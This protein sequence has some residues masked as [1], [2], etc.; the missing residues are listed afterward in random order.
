[1]KRARTDSAKDQ[2][3]TELLEAALNEFYEKGFFAARMDDIAARAKLSK[4]TLYL[5]FENK[6]DVFRS[7]IETFAVANAS[8]LEAALTSTPSLFEGFEAMTKLVPLILHHSPMPKLI[9]VLVGDSTSFPET[10][11]SYRRNVI[12]RLHGALERAV[13]DAHA[14]GEI[15]APDAATTARLIVAPLA[16]SMLWQ[17]VFA[18]GAPPEKQLDLDKLLRTHL[19][20]LCKALAPLPA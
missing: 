11:E 17:V 9:K 12:D 10:V 5:Y 19:E 3:R 6:H 4:G 7:I 16:L 13:A 15:R 1:M 18:A 2:R 8:R 14:R 20:Y